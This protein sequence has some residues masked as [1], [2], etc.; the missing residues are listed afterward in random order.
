[1][2]FHSDIGGQ[3][4]TA[5]MP[6]AL[7]QRDVAFLGDA[8]IE[9][10][11]KVTNLCLLCSRLIASGYREMCCV[12]MGVTGDVPISLCSCIKFLVAIITSQCKTPCVLLLGCGQWIGI[13][14]GTN[15]KQNLPV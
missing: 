13:I 12:V 3:C 5:N 6:N 10:C 11:I 7:Q 4:K 9:V 1:V 2:L 15:D 14:S 8:C